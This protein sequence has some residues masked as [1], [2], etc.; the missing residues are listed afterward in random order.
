[1][2]NFR[3]IVSVLLCLAMIFSLASSFSYAAELRNETPKAKLNFVTI[4]DPHFYPESL[5]GGKG[6][7]WQKYAS[8]NT[9]Q[10]AQSEQMMRTAIETAVARNPELDYILIPGDLTKDGEY[11]AHTE[12][13]ALLEEYEARYG[14][15]FF[16]IN[17]NH[18]VNQDRALTFEN[19]VKER[20]RPIQAHEFDD[21]Y[22]NL[23]YDLAFARYAE[24]SEKKVNGLSYAADLKDENGNESYRLIVID[25]CKYTFD[26]ETADHKTDGAMT[27]ELLSWV[28][29]LAED[30]YKNGK[31]PLVMTHHGLAAHM[32]TE[33]SITHAFPLD[34]YI[35]VAEQLA[36]WGIHYAFTGHL[37]TDDIACVINDDGEVLYDCETASVSSYPCTYREMTIET[38]A[39]GESEMSFESVDFDDKAKFTYD[40]ITYD[41]GTYKNT[42][43]NNAFGGLKSENGRADA[44]IFLVDIVKSFLGGYIEQIS[45]AGSVDAFLKIMDIDLGAIIGGFLEPYIGDGIKVGGYNIF[46]VDNIMWF[47]NDLLGQVYDLYI[48]NPDVLYNLLED[49]VSELTSLQV[50][51]K[52]CTA[53]LESHGIGDA[54]RPGN[55]G[56]LI[57]TA[58]TY[59]YDGN[60]DAKD[61][62]FLQDAIA[63]CESGETITKLFD[64]LIDLLLHDLIEDNILGKLEIRLGKL[65]NDDVIGKALGD[66]IDYLVNVLL[67]GNPTYMNLVDTVFALEILPYKDLYDVLDQ[68]A[69]QKYLTFSQFEG[70]GVF[71]AYVL[72]DFTGD[73][74]PAEKGDYGVAYSTEKVEVPV[75]R[76]NYRLPTTVSVTLGEEKNKSAYISWFSKY[77]V[78][79]D[80]EIYKADSEPAFTGT[81]TT[82]ADFGIDIKSEA[83]TRS[84][85]GIDIGI[86]GFIQYEFAVN[87]HIVTLTDLEEGATYYYR[88]GSAEK[89]WWSDTGVIR[90]GD[91]SKEVTFFHMTDPQSQ[92]EKQYKRAWAK[93]VEE[94]YKTHPDGDFIINTGDLS[95]HGN[96]FKHWGW[97]LNTAS[98]ELMGTYLMPTSGNHEGHGENAIVNNFVVP[99]APEQDTTGGVY[100]SFDYNNIHFAV[101]N[102]E[103]LGENEGLSDEQIEWLKNDMNKSDAQWNFVA[104]HKA[105][106]S[107]GS[108]YKDKDVCAI[109]EQLSVLMPELD[110]DMVFQGHDHVYMRTGSL[111]NNALTGYDSTYLN[112]DG[113]VYKAQIQ[114]TGTTYV[115]SGC[116]GV[117][118]YIQN[119]PSLT[120]EYF[121]RGDKMLSFDA[122]MFSAVRIVDG[123]LYFDAYTVTEQG[124]TAVDS[125]AIQK[126]TTQGD[127]A[128]GYTPP[129][130]DPA[131]EDKENIFEKIL[132]VLAK[133]LK[134]MMN[135]VKIYIF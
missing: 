135:I 134:V 117:K 51:D 106:Y 112:F 116:S 77:S 133:V 58:M 86:A 45:E 68:L 4:S 132:S 71:V 93:V 65:M 23:G 22:K 62:E 53:L 85:P 21:V 30:A 60:E 16:I 104:L 125:I 115:I 17:G 110:V 3:R 7:A 95:D 34:N 39:D 52:P 33:P 66:G 121:P 127:V 96:N 80:I 97:L 9:K 107:Q 120:D 28:K 6:E 131:E 78:G 54:S 99:N 13:A 114:P 75:T 72:N 25:S 14:V 56:D 67:Q 69:I 57:L 79:G 113:K 91:G 119:D 103:N 118:S 15:D 5:M 92:N 123:V 2:K 88:I 38:Y 128:Q 41:N 108:H 8:T 44:A 49:L 122:P 64:L 130:E 27:D 83:V 1:M 32:E 43:F 90:T 87:R 126:D 89:G 36:S 109:R 20:A 102:S 70:I 24:D 82:N 12:F 129:A 55:L 73:K 59:W 105:V 50:S 19:G 31:T 111:V 63:K 76:E 46:S 48:K 84:F 26:P 124:V 18:D 81:P 74:N 11:V 10:F 98:D 35:E 37:H 61:N 47:I 42:V 101:L 29:A 100:Y 94:A 40:G